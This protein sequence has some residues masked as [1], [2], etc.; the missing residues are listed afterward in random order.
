M[1]TLCYIKPLKITKLD[2]NGG[3]SDESVTKTLLAYQE[4]SQCWEPCSWNWELELLRYCLSVVHSSSL[5][6]T[7][8]WVFHCWSLHCNHRLICQRGILVFHGEVNSS[9]RAGWATL[10]CSRPIPL[11]VPKHHLP[12][13]QQHSWRD[14][15][16]GQSSPRPAHAH[17][18]LAP[19][20]MW[21]TEHRLRP[22]LAAVEIQGEALVRGHL[23]PSVTTGLTVYTCLYQK[24]TATKY[25]RLFFLS[26]RTACWF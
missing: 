19:S 20:H 12:L 26:K 9:G 10:V 11:T 13:S 14:R 21:L 25:Q 16:D 6:P 22:V 1:L 7:P 5:P 2:K 18:T 8:P 4:N 17:C 23:S 15:G 3:K 24:V